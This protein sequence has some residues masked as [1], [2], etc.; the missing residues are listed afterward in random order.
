MRCKLLVFG[1]V[2]Y[3]AGTSGLHCYERAR[4]VVQTKAVAYSAGGSIAEV[5]VGA[6]CG[7]EAE[8]QL[9]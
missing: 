7:D 4:C 2:V 9:P 1:A 3:A 5:E 6:G 8:V